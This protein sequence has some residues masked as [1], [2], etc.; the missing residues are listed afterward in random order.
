MSRV[1]EKGHLSTA[2]Y[3]EAREQKQHLQPSELAGASLYG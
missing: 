1:T 2:Q 3:I